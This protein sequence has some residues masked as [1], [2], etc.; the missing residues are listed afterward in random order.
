VP[1]SLTSPCAP[2][3][4]A[5]TRTPQDWLEKREL[6][7]HSL[8]SVESARVWEAL[9]EYSQRYER[10]RMRLRDALTSVADS[11][12]AVLRELPGV[13]AAERELFGR[14]SV[15]RPPAALRQH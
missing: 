7:M 13:I 9:H 8:R 3:P 6:E 15:S 5:L 10:E 2:R 4:A 14:T 1:R 11:H 12:R